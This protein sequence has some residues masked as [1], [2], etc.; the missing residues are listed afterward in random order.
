MATTI[1]AQEAKE[2]FSRV[3]TAAARGEEF[4]VTKRGKPWTRITPAGGE[5]EFGFLGL[6]FTSDLTEPLSDAE[7]AEWGVA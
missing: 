7:L 2:H 1:T 4:V 3:M 5:P 6:T